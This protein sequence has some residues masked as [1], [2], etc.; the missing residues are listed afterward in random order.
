MSTE[1]VTFI[2][3]ISHLLTNLSLASPLSNPSDPI[4]SAEYILL[5][6]PYLHTQPLHL[7]H[8]A[9]IDPFESFGR[10]LSTRHNRIRH[11]PYV[12]GYGIAELHKRLLDRTKGI[13][14]V[15]CS[16]PTIKGVKM[17]Q[18][19]DGLMDQEQFATDILKYIKDELKSDLLRIL[20]TIDVGR[21]TDAECYDALFKVKN[22]EELER[23]ANTILDEI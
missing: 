15:L 4:P 22:W 10:S 11:A 21:N 6:T 5:L 16:A 13:I 14:I 8:D 19:L 9:P 18:R 23:A 12:A 20:V 7:G 2:D 17:N 3:H 1:S